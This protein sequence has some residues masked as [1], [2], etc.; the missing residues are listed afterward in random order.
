MADHWY[1]LFGEQ[2]IAA[3]RAWRSPSVRRNF[4]ADTGLTD[5]TSETYQRRFV[6]WAAAGH[7]LP[8]ERS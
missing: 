3:D 5:E 7:H 6:E 8:V 1:G 2:R 4:E